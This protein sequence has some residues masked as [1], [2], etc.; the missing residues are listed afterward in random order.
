M[1]S[2]DGVAFTFNDATETRTT[3][4]PPQAI[5]LLVGPEAPP[6]GAGAWRL[7]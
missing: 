6:A 1:R 5:Y 2:R 4:A 7:A 3:L